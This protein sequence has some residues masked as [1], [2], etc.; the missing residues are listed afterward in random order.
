M[1]KD[2]LVTKLAARAGVGRAQAKAVLDALA[3]MG[4]GHGQPM[5]IEALDPGPGAGWPSKASQ[6][7]LRY[8]PT[9]AEVARLIEDAQGHQL[10]LEFLIE[11]ELGSVAMTFGVHAFTV[12]S[13]RRHLGAE[14]G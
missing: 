5:P 13:A 2:E 10:G 6:E 1:P 12:H 8:Q 4:E 14:Q 11:G 3:E 9:G 7:P